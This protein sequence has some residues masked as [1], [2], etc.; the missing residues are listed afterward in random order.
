MELFEG[1]DIDDKKKRFHMAQWVNPDRGEMFFAN[2]VVFVEGETEKVAIPFLAQ[3]MGLYDADIS[4]IDCGSKYNL[5]LYVR[6]ANAFQMP[7]MVVHD[8]DP[9]PADVEEAKRREKERTFELNQIIAELVDEEL[10]TI[11]VLSPDFEGA[12]GVSRSQG[13][14]K[15]KALAALDHFEDKSLGE[16]PEILVEL[17]AKAYG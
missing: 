8:E 15:G 16:L 7:H 3:K 11:F 6:I 4:V 9:V 17:V 12:S 2:R 1:D 13:D 10:G 5:P 14:K